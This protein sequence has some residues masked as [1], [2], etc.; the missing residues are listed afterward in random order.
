MLRRPIL[1]VGPSGMM[2]LVGF[3]EPDVANTAR[4]DAVHVLPDRHIG[5]PC[6]QCQRA[7]YRGLRHSCFFCK[8]YHLCG[9]CFASNNRPESP[10]H[11]YYHIMQVFYTRAAYELY[12]GGEPYT[13]TGDR[14]SLQC[15]L[16]L[17]L[18]FT[19]QTL[20]QHLLQ[21][22]R[23][24]PDHRDYV[25]MTYLYYVDRS[26]GNVAPTPPTAADL[27]NPG[28]V[29]LPDRD[30]DNVPIIELEIL[31]LAQV[32]PARSANREAATAAARLPAAAAVAGAGASNTDMDHV[33]RALR[34]VRDQLLSLGPNSEAYESLCME[35]LMRARCLHELYVLSNNITSDVD[36][37][38][39]QIEGAAFARLHGSRSTFVLG[40]VPLPAASSGLVPLIRQQEPAPTVAGGRAAAMHRLDR[41]QPDDA[42]LHPSMNW[43]F[44]RHQSGNQFVFRD[45][46]A[47]VAARYE[48]LNRYAV[49][50]STHQ[51][52]R[53]PHGDQAGLPIWIPKSTQTVAAAAKPPPPPAR[54]T[55]AA[56]TELPVDV[57]E[58]VPPEN[59]IDKLDLN[60]GRFLCSRL[61]ERFEK[62]LE[63][64]E[65]EGKVA[66]AR[67]VDA[68]FCSMLSE[69]DLTSVPVDLLLMQEMV[70]TATTTV[71]ANEPKPLEEP[72]TV[73]CGA[74]EGL[75]QLP[76]LMQLAQNAIQAP[77]SAVDPMIKYFNGLVDYKNWLGRLTISVEAKKGA[78]EIEAK[79]GSKEPEAQPTSS[80]RYLENILQIISSGNNGQDGDDGPNDQN[81]IA[82][83]DRND[84]DDEDD[85][86]NDD[87]SNDSKMGNDFAN[88]ENDFNGNVAD[89]TYP[90]EINIFDQPEEHNQ[91]PVEDGLPV[92]PAIIESELS[93]SEVSYDEDEDLYNDNNDYEYYL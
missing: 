25:M 31:R 28:S 78:T 15:A 86:S 69:E 62:M 77:E 23:D 57:A 12:F 87:D 71:A 74:E 36:R 8:D 53:G 50:R 17:E 21:S 61:K 91:Q 68:V 75:N 72:L 24:H 38:T 42:F 6:R 55:G 10:H 56:I 79:E 67:F 9:N 64:T 40:E 92:A 13:G 22:H 81:P 2:D 33:A 5:F 20:Y 37:L 43:V 63:N 93:G 49:L 1:E 88:N 4:S 27:P 48:N 89:N 59:P 82:F 70:S 52:E 11:K 90:Y 7:D 60:D 34:D 46:Q 76:R 3:E 58:P 66:K 30:E 14:Q 39:R 32:E 44:P 73:A 26:S 80:N 16:C 84:G 65:E 47:P 51:A 19:I 85:E 18:G 45:S 41:F 54:N 83:I 29:V 35:L